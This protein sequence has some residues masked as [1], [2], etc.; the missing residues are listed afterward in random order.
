[1]RTPLVLLLLTSLAAAQSDPPETEESPVTDVLH[2]VELVDAYRWLEGSDAPELGAPDPELDARVADWTDAQNAYTRGVLD[3]LPS[4]AKLETRM[5]RLLEVGFVGSPTM[6]G[7]RYF[8]SKQE[9]KQPQP[10]LYVREGLE[11]EPRVLLDPTAV[12]PSGLSTLAWYLPDAEGDLLAFGM[13]RSG[14]ENSTL[15]VLE[16]ESGEWLADEIPGKV[17][18]VGWL[19]DSS[20]LFY[21]DLESVEDPYSGR[22]MFHEL[23]RHPRQDRMLFRQYKEGPLATTYGPHATISRDARWMI[24][25]YS[26]GTRDNDLWA[27]DLDRWFRTGEFVPTDV[28]VGEKAQSSGT[29]LGDTLYMLTNLGAPNSRV[30]AV[31]LTDPARERWREI[32]PQREDAVLQ[33]VQLARGVLVAQYLHQASSRIELFDL[34]G[35]S[36][37]E[38]ALPGIGRASLSAERDRTEAFL[39]F[40]SF[41]TPPTI[42]RVDLATGERAL[43]ERVDVPVDPEL[44]VVKQVWYPSKDGTKV[45]MF[46]IHRRGLE[47]DGKNPTILN[48]YGGFNISR[49]PRFRATMFPWYEGG[50]VRAVA[51]LRGGGEYGREWHEDGRLE[52]KQNTFDDFIAAAEWLIEQGYTSPEH[53]GVTGASNGGLLTGAALT[54]RPDLF[55]A[56]ISGVPLLDMLRYQHFLMARYWIPEYGSSEDPTAFEYIR[57]YSPYHNVKPGV[58]YPATLFTAGENDARVHPMHARKMTAL[59]QAASAADPRTE[60]ML[61]WVEREAGHGGGKPLELRVQESVDESLFLMWQLGMLEKGR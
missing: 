38:L 3:R 25:S 40:S 27:I 16:V 22:I 56:V 35:Q 9:G 47:L 8:F 30:F 18:P 19:P 1:M 44:V 51:N 36:R 45:S 57:R 26:T 20:G 42:Y 41:N 43:W 59:M 10:I 12:D 13:Y 55:S 37:G 6:R 7:K 52:R 50:G 24:L 33:G 21:R 53:L 2:G 4:R 54:Q 48:G 23:G 15:Y 32:I 14:S 5:T 60:P 58:R 17:R 61:L 31:D 46:V 34:D 28:L 49:T 29:V 11:G 39:S